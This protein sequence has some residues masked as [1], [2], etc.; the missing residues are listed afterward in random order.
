MSQKQA[1]ALLSLHVRIWEKL[2]KSKVSI[3]LRS[4]QA[5]STQMVQMEL[6][7]AIGNCSVAKHMQRVC[8][9]SNSQ[10]FVSRFTEKGSYPSCAYAVI[11]MQDRRLPQAYP[12]TS[13]GIRSPVPRAS[14]P[15]E[16]SQ[17]KALKLKYPNNPKNTIQVSKLQFCNALQVPSCSVPGTCPIKVP[18]LKFPR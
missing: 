1:C 3:Q 16:A 2:S 18:E 10:N 17:V 7:P 5:C 13:P 12:A 4:Y 14:D 15:S 11:A 6:P 9:L 8:V